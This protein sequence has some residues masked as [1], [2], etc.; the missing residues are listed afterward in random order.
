[1]STL[2]R[3]HNII[4][5][6]EFYI[7]SRFLILR[8]FYKDTFTD[9]PKKF[10]P[11]KTLQS[12]PVL[13]LSESNLWND[14]DNNLNRILTAGKVQNL[15]VGALKLNEIELPENSVFCFWEHIGRPSK[16]RGFVVGR[17]IR[18]GCILPTI[19]G[20]LCQLSNALYDAALKAGFEIIERHKHTQVIPGSLAEQDR[21]AT[22]KWNYVDLRFKVNT[23]IRIE[24]DLTAEQLIVKFKG[25]KQQKQH[26]SHSNIELR[27]SSILNDCYSCGNVECFRYPSSKTKNSQEE[28]TT[29]VLDEKWP[30]HETYVNSI[31]STK[32]NFIVPFGRVPRFNI[33]RYTWQTVSKGTI[34]SFP[35]LALKRAISIRLT[36]RFK[37]NLPSTYLKYDQA[38]VSAVKSKVPVETNHIVISQNLLPY[39]WKAGL[40]WGRTFDVLMTRLPMQTI[41]ERLDSAFNKY[42]E[43]RTLNDFRADAELVNLESIALT[44]ARYIIT[45]HTEIAG[46]F[47][48]KSHQLKWKTPPIQAESRKGTRILYPGASL[49]RKGAYEVRQLAYELNLSIVLSGHTFE[50][51]AFWQGIDI[52]HASGDLFDD[53]ALVIMP[54]YIE[55]QPRLLIKALSYG[56]PVIATTACGLPEMDNLTIVPLGDYEALKSAIL[57]KINA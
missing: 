2:P 10:R 17:E 13:A 32:D 7:K 52:H 24:V 44:R 14:D 5:T 53:V 23:A 39:A 16:S 50:C 25:F 11:G 3:S 49:A 20:G 6:A 57:E 12:A 4:R 46:I 56:I 26:L 15:R 28:S 27:T 34:S 37:G 8:R 42:A 9:I 22:I 47:S 40:L 1:M 18:E 19:G 43:S 33:P 48:Q 21:D 41:Q 35:V 38:I 30:E 55:N 31:A 54:A 45:P 29:F 36:N 51:E